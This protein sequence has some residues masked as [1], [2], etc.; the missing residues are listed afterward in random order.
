MCDLSLFTSFQRRG[1]S[2]S[3]EL[4]FLSYSSISSCASSGCQLVYTTHTDSAQEKRRY[5]NRVCGILSHRYSGPDKT[6]HLDNSTNA[7]P[8]WNWLLC[9]VYAV[10]AVAGSDA[11]GHI[12]EETNNARCLFPLSLNPLFIEVLWSSNAARG[13]FWSGVAC[14]IYGFLLTIFFLFCIPSIDV[15][16]SSTAPQPFVIVYDMALGRG[17]AI[18]MTLLASLGLVFVRHLT[19][20]L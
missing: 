8:A 18:F 9:L 17:G 20:S 10:G 14:S 12:A 4:P 13:V 7:P 2:T 5:L 11:S 3:F 19:E 16:L 15:V 6:W 1:P